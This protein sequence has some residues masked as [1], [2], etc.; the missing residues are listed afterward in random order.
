M[1]LRHQ[2]ISYIC[3]LIILLTTRKKCY[4][5]F[6]VKICILAVLWQNQ[7][8]VFEWKYFVVLRIHSDW[9][10]N[11]LTSKIFIVME[12]NVKLRCEI[13]SYTRW[14]IPKIGKWSSLSLRQACLWSKLVSSYNLIRHWWK[15]I[16]IFFSLFS[17]MKAKFWSTTSAT[18]Q[19]TK[20]F[21][22]GS[23]RRKRRQKV[24]CKNPLRSDSGL[25]QS[26]P[27]FRFTIRFL[28]RLNSIL[29][30]GKNFQYLMR[31][32]SFTFFPGILEHLKKYKIIKF[33]P[34]FTIFVQ[35][36]VCLHFLKL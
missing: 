27:G 8:A 3:S 21:I 9:T 6:A 33:C 5:S 31:K 13:N 7:L 22:E 34:L 15:T 28:F 30:K 32:F 14:A 19:S 29:V 35:N 12:Q 1:D 25:I 26:Y 18:R 2:T 20:I 11:L 4:Y 23:R 36:Q 17:E 16:C 24:S 10:Q